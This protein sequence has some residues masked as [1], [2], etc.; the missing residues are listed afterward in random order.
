M[1]TGEVS[2]NEGLYLYIYVYTWRFPKIGVPPNHPFDRIFHYKAF[3]YWVLPFQD[4]AIYI[5]IYTYIY[6][7]LPK[8]V[9]AI[10]AP[11]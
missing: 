7:M 5:Y 1:L 11:T 2:I 3:S 6:P 10:A 4:T 8:D 9:S